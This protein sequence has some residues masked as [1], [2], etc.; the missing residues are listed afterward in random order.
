MK[1]R[2]WPVPRSVKDIAAAVL[3]FKDF[4]TLFSGYMGTGTEHIVF[5]AVFPR[6]ETIP[7]NFMTIRNVFS[8]FSRIGDYFLGCISERF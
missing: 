5:D 7:D 1:A 2:P 4:F 3:V 6:A 8:A